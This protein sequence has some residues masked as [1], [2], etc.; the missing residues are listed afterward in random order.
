MAEN[1]QWQHEIPNRT[2][3]PPGGQPSPSCPVPNTELD[4]SFRI[5][6][7]TSDI[8]RDFPPPHAPLPLAIER[9][10]VRAPEVTLSVE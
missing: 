5:E 7:E 1:A 9:V 10:T 4:A 3:I 8:G 6:M 2:Q